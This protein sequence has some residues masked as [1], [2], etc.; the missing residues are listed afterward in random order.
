MG[1]S[2]KSSKK[3]SMS[4]Q[5]CPFCEIP[6][7]RIVAQNR[8][9]MWISDGF[10][11]SPGHSLVIPKR[12]VRSFFDVSTEERDD[13]LTLLD[14]AKAHALA[15]LQPDGFNIGIND[16]PAAG[17]TVPHLHIHLIPRFTGDVA[18]PRGGIRWVIPAK[19][20]YWSQ[21]D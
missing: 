13:L 15:S 19:A 5:T 20:D 10:P 6:T 7:C 17:Q 11:V 4:S 21:R 2:L 1:R 9:A 14:H 8:H 12:H 18:D 16:G 3:S